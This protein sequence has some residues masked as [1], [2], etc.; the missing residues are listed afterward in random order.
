MGKRGILGHMGEI[1]ESGLS[2]A[3][4]LHTERVMPPST[5]RFCPV[6]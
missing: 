6:M 1:V 5:R 4:G 2:P 3:A